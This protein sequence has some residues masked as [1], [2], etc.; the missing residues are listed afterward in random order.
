VCYG[1]GV[2]EHV[3]GG[4]G[5]VVL[6]MPGAAL[7]GGKELG[8]HLGVVLPVVVE[9]AVASA[10]VPVAGSGVPVGWMGEEVVL[11]QPVEPVVL[12]C[13]LVQG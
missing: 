6:P 12:G 1:G 2:V 11:Q 10:G 5:Q 3:A 7:V 13:C 8:D 4:V 9:L